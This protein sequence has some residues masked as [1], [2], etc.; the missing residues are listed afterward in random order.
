MIEQEI[1][2]EIVPDQKR[3]ETIEEMNIKVGAL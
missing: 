3:E 1:I 2:T